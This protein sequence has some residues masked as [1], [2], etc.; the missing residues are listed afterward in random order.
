MTT[1]RHAALY[2]QITT[3]ASSIK[4]DISNSSPPMPSKKLTLLSSRTLISTLLDVCS[5]APTTIAGTPLS[6]RT[7]PLPLP[8]RRDAST[9]LWCT[10]GS[11]THVRLRMLAPALNFPGNPAPANGA[12]AGILTTAYAIA[13]I[14]AGVHDGVV[15]V[16][17]AVDGAWQWVAHH[18]MTLRTWNTNNHQMTYGVLGAAFLALCQYMQLAGFG[19]VRFTVWDG[20]NQVGAGAL[21]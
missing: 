12:V 4:T 14:Q 16:S 7:L 8:P 21:E 1:I 3:W 11:S 15:P 20:V 5:N 9:I 13:S 10:P 6:A 2:G 19:T 17:Q 18:G